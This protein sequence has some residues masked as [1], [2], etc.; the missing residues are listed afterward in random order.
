MAHSGLYSILGFNSQS[1]LGEFSCVAPPTGS[2]FLPFMDK[3]EPTSHIGKLFKLGIKVRNKHDETKAYS[4]VATFCF[5]V[6]FLFVLNKT[7][8]IYFVL[9]ERDSKKK[10]LQFM[11]W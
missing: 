6:T 7:E 11:S 8:A 4:V 9:I 1:S 5:S 10:Q 2:S 3:Y